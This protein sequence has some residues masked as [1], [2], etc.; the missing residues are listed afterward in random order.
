MINYFSNK[1]H[2]PTY[3]HIKHVIHGEHHP[4]DGKIYKDV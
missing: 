1:M 2:F 4:Y 3:F